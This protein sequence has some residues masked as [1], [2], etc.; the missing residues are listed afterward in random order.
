MIVCPECHHPNREGTVFCSECGGQLPGPDTA[1]TDRIEIEGAQAAPPRSG[2]IRGAAP[3]TDSTAWASLQLLESGQ[4]LPLASRMEFTLGRSSEGQPILPDID[5]EPYQ[6]HAQGVSRLHAIIKCERG[7]ISLIDLGS[8]NGT[9]V[10]GRRIP[11]N[12]EQPIQSGDTISLGRLKFQL[13]AKDA[14]KG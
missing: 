1:I 6:A 3:S 12:L 14:Q 9:Y 4:V 7:L 8:S 10:N 11:P 13:M 2:P 5:L